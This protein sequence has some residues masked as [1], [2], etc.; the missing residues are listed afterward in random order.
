MKIAYCIDSL[1]LSGGTER[2]LTTK[3]NWLC[4]QPGIK[5]YIITLQESI[6]PFFPLDGKVK[7]IT[8]STVNYQ[9][10]LTQTLNEIRPN[11]TIA[12]SGKACT[13]LPRMKDGSKKILEFHYTKNFLVNFVSSLHRIRF[14]WLHLM[15]MR[16]MQWRLAQLAKHYDLFV[17]LTA[18]DV[19][20]WGNPSNMT[21]VYN[22]LSF[23][24]EQKSTCA[25]HKIIAVGSFTSVK[26]MDQL[27]KAFA[28]ISSKYLDWSVDIYGSGQEQR[29]LEELITK[30][31]LRNRVSLFAPVANINEKLIGASIYAFPSRSDG[32]GLVITEAMECGLPTVAMDCECGPREIIT[33]ETGIIV[34]DKDINAFAE[35]LE[36]LIID[37]ELRKSMGYNAAKEVKRFYSENIMPQW[38][39]L[40]D[41]LLSPGNFYFQ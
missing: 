12:V 21:Y 40:F 31:N 20:L 34:P 1:K 24:S 27:I 22:P 19:T 32:F 30:Y 16:W 11:I 35:A 8:L 6:P 10:E 29:Y 38:I 33:K 18:R 5:V 2:V 23:R 39:N 41:K 7:R 14:R 3:T 37:E 4:L 26:G 25:N 36:K 17:G 13:L 15:K 28:L 9:Q